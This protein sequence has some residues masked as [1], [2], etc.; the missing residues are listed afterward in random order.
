MLFHLDEEDLKKIL[1]THIL[2]NH[3]MPSSSQGFRVSAA[4]IS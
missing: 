1:T 3:N 2:I 4:L